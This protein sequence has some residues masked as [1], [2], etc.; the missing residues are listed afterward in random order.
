MDFGLAKVVEWDGEEGLLED[1]QGEII[2]FSQNDIRPKDLQYVEVGTVVVVPEDGYLELTSQGFDHY[3]SS[4]TDQMQCVHMD[5]KNG[6]CEDC[7][8]KVD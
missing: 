1:E 5:I 4:D 7:G 8:E 6:F 2:R 3:V